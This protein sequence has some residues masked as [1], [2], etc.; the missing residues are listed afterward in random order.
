ME[1]I[2]IPRFV[3]RRKGV[4]LPAHWGIQTE[5]ARLAGFSQS[6]VSRMMNGH[7]KMSPVVAEL[8]ARFQS[9]AQTPDEQGNGR[10]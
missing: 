10:N 8:L 2:S 3:H 7:R 5:I 1:D 9:A 6:Y 4:L